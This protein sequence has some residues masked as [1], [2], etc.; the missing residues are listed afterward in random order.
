M[1]QATLPVHP[2]NGNATPLG[3]SL[4][5]LPKSDQRLAYVTAAIAPYLE[6]ASA[7]EAESSPGETET[8]SGQGKVLFN[9]PI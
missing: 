8:G 3:I 4:L 5:S 1:L 6:E 2:Q 9:C 7:S